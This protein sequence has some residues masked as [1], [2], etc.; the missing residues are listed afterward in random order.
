MYEEIF[1]MKERSIFQKKEQIC[2]FL[3]K[4]EGVFKAL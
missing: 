1:N 3:C 2:V 4:N